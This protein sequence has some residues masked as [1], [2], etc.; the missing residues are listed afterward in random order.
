LRI[1]IDV[2]PHQIETER[3]TVESRTQPSTPSTP[4]QYELSLSYVRSSNS[5]KSLL[6]RGKGHG[7]QG[8]NTFFD[9]EGT[10]DQDVFDEWVRD[11][12][13]DVTGEESN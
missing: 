4:P 3:I 10:L 5:G 7:V 1:A 9:E 13:A 12:V 6:H 11:L 2:Q 8:Y